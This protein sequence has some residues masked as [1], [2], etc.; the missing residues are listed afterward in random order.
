MRIA[1]LVF[2]LALATAALAQT[3]TLTLQDDVSSKMPSGTVF[4]AK[5]GAGKL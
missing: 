5:D 2:V 4:T 3:T 1:D